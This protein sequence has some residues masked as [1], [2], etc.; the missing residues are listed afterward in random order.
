MNEQDDPI[1]E[2]VRRIREQLA[3]RFDFDVR[4][5]GDNARRR[6]QLLWKGRLVAPPSRPAITPKS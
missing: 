3:A 1:V 6:E 5:I 2:E 4:R